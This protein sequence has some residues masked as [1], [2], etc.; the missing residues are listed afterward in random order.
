MQAKAYLENWSIFY[1]YNLKWLLNK[2]CPVI[3]CDVLVVKKVKKNK[4]KGYIAH[5][6]LLFSSISL[7]SSTEIF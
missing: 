5:I 2:Q 7:K 3:S 4:E 1:S 6:A